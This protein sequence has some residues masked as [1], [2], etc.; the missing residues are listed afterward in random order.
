MNSE[1]LKEAVKR[2]LPQWLREDPDL[3][4]YILELTRQEYADRAETQE[5]VL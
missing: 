2:E 1:S 4:A 3:R 5:S